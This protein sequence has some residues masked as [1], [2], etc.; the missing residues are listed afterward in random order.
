MLDTT[1]VSGLLVLAPLGH[2]VS[3][4]ALA[5]APRWGILRRAD[6]AA[7]TPINGRVVKVVLLTMQAVLVGSGVT[8]LWAR[9]DILAGGRLAVATTA[10]LALLWSWRL[11][12]Q[13]WVYGPVLLASS[14]LRLLHRGLVALFAFMGAAYAVACLHAL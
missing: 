10:C 11:G 5:L 13:V 9:G 12:I 8:V 3:I 2:F 7:L 4:P 14:G 1:L 6:L